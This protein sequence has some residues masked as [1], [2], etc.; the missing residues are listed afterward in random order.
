MVLFKGFSKY[1][2]W[3]VLFKGFSKYVGG[4]STPTLEL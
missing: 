1:V 2:G 3:M 4:D